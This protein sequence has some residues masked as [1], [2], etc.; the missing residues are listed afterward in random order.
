MKET[1]AHLI[2][3]YQS[4]LD[5][6]GYPLIALLM[7]VE[8]TIFPIPSELIIPFA[9]QR[10]QAA[11]H[12]S[13]PGVVIAGALGSW[14]GAT[15]MYWASRLA[16]RPLVVRYGAYF[17]VPEAKLRAA[18]RWALRFGS[19]GVFV[20]RLLPV[21]RHLIGIPMG[22]VKMDFKLYSVFTLVGSTLWCAVLAWVGV[23]AGQDASLMQGDL[24]SVTKWLAG[25]VAFLA[26]I[27]YI[28]VH[29]YMRGDGPAKEL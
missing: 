14:V 26:L 8:S 4:T 20:A 27:Y 6:G 18:E 12:L 25:A 1:I 21:V 22:I 10:A 23:K 3:W 15:I 13:V 11:G 19:F 16:G 7:A 28:L 24:H 29:R 5:A 9:A 17:L 2:Q